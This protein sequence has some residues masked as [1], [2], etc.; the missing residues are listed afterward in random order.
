VSA[1]PCPASE[2]AARTD[3]SIIKYEDLRNIGHAPGK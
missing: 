3:A 1:G 2:A